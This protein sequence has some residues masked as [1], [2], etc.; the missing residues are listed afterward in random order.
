MATATPHRPGRIRKRPADAVVAPNLP[1]YERARTSF[2]WDDARRALDGLPGGRGLNIAHEAVDRHA[3]GALRD[4]VALR[5][6]GRSGDVVDLTY[7]DLRA[8]TNRF[9]NVLARL[10][11][12]PGDRVFALTGRI[13][14][15]YVAALGTLKGGCVF[16]PLFSAFG[17]EPVRERLT[18]GDGRVLVTTPALF[19]A[20][21][22]PSSPA[23][24]SSSTCCSSASPT[25]SAPCRTARTCAPL[26]AAESPELEIPPTDPGAARR[27]CTSPAARRD[28]RR[29]RCTSTRRSSPTTPPAAIALDLHPD[30]VFWCT[31]DPGWV[32]G[33]SYGIIAPLTHGVTSVVDEARLR[34]RA[35]GT[36]SS[37][38]SA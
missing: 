36:A 32:T 35:A 19:R 34:R 15:L 17:P 29:A 12:E 14:E 6:L 25:R 13:P 18:L 21:S 33:T 11:V 10:G 7:A 4:S 16:C 3:A 22:R 38:S 27:C 24:R 26:L 23:C 9:A 2:S 30:D 31:A 8:A 5:W 20:R 37:P 1:D 28:A